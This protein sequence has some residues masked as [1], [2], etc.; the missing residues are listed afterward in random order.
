[1]TDFVFIV[2]QICLRY[3]NIE[4]GSLWLN[5]AYFS[6]LFTLKIKWYDRTDPV[7]EKVFCL[8]IL[9]IPILIIWYKPDRNGIWIKKYRSFGFKQF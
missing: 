3:I 6:S 8:R 5:E 9:F 1:L 4:V 2:I 7:P